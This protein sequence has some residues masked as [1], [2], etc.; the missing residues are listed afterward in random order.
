MERYQNI[1]SRKI[2]FPPTMSLE[3]QDIIN[4]LLRDQSERLGR[5]KGTESVKQHSWFTGFQ[6][7]S[8][9]DKSMKAPF[10]PE[11][12]PE[13]ISDESSSESEEDRPTKRRSTLCCMEET[14]LTLMNSITKSDVTEYTTKSPYTSSI[15]RSDG[16]SLGDNSYS[17]HISN[18]QSFQKKNLKHMIINNM[19]ACKSST[20]SSFI[21]FYIL[22]AL[23]KD[24]G[25]LS[26]GISRRNY[27]DP[28]SCK[29]INVVDRYPRVSSIIDNVL[30]PED[31]ASF[32]FPSGVRLKLI[33]RCTLEK[34]AERIGVVG[35][36]G[37]RYQLHTVRKNK[38]S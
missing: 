10:I 33:P 22:S 27:L 28:F 12:M 2:N 4:C 15:H 11:L 34:G 6:W 3:V 19:A 20:S 18:L 24:V 36:K 13:I 26:Y 29:S 8:L 25:P 37:D 14:A 7:E 31:V 23:P 35:E 17:S 30:A 5:I 32:C 21:Q 38:C 16:Y 9:L 1:V